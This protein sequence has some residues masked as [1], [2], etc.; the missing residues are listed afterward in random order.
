MSEPCDSCAAYAHPYCMHPKAMRPGRPSWAAQF[1]ADIRYDGNC[2]S[3]NLF[4]KKPE[5]ATAS[6]GG[7]SK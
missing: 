6:E 1:A 3:D 2:K 4:A 7:G 5:A